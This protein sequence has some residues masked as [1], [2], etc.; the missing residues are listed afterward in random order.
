MT[1]SSS[2]SN[3]IAS[4]GI[5]ADEIA[6]EI[7]SD[8]ARLLGECSLIAD[9]IRDSYD[10]MTLMFNKYPSPADGSDDHII[11]MS[12][13][14][15]SIVQFSGC[16]D[17]K[18]PHALKA[19]DLYAGEAGWEKLDTWFRD[20]RDS[21][22]AHSFGPQRQNDLCALLEWNGQR[23][24]VRFTAI[25]DFSVRYQGPHIR[26]RDQ[27]LKFMKIALDVAEA[28]VRLKRRELHAK[29]L[30][31]GPDALFR[32]PDYRPLIPSPTDIRIGRP[33]FRSKSKTPR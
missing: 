10:S 8:D 19:F 31:I 24:R 33:S 11:R 32:Y 1:G 28:R 7:D 29:M 9:Q 13:F 4:G 25:A 26:E 22:A 2:H 21:Y 14:R 30:E 27:I 20:L 3:V 12:L 16:F 23:D 15:D 6:K 18:N 17:P 5:R